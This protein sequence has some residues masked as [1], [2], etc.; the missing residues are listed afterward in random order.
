MLLMQLN[1]VV[2]PE[3][4]GPIRPQIWPSDTVNETWSSAVSPPK[5]TTTSLMSSN[6]A[7]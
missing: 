6:V 2:L 5:R 1:S 4:F 3:P 7:G